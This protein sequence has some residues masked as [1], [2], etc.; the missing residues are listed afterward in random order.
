[1]DVS[2]PFLTI[3]KSS[4]VLDPFLLKQLIYEEYFLEFTA[5]MLLSSF[6]V[7]QS[8]HRTL[9]KKLGLLYFIFRKKR[10]TQTFHQIQVLTLELPVLGA[11]KAN[12]PLLT[13]ASKSVFVFESV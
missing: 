10:R 11:L 1:M 6:T 9:R 7:T 5:S 3:K 12:Q 2:A 8:S 13:E 4:D